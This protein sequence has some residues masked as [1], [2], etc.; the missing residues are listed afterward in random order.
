M[1]MRQQKNS[2]T[3]KTTVIPPSLILR[4]KV[5]VRT[6]IK[7][8][9]IHLLEISFTSSGVERRRRVPYYILEP[10]TFAPAG[11]PRIYK[12]S[13]D[14]DLDLPFMEFVA[15]AEA[16]AKWL[17]IRAQ[18][19]FYVPFWQ[20]EGEGIGEVRS[21]YPE[22]WERLENAKEMQHTWARTNRNFHM[23]VLKGRGPITS[24]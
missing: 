8:G 3:S 17:E 10:W 2:K 23:A 24:N 11:E 4:T 12:N 6:V 18:S 22:L 9:L 19:G 16:A 13:P 7:F 20:I 21:K 5:K 1:G 14:D 15:T